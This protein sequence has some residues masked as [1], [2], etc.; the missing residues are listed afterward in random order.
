MKDSDRSIDVAKKLHVHFSQPYREKEGHFH[1]KTC[2]FRQLPG[3]VCW[4][5]F[6]ARAAI[7]KRR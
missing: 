2:T 7:E 1:A 4:R 6:Y 5:N 3:S